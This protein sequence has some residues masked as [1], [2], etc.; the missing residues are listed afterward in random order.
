M[1]GTLKFLFGIEIIESEDQILFKI[2]NF[3]SVYLR[4]PVTEI[5]EFRTTNM[6]KRTVKT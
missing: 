1:R 2:F 6:H 4:Q 5:F 3:E